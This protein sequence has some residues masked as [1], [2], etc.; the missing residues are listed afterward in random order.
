M[1]SRAALQHSRRMRDLVCPPRPD[2]FAAYKCGVRVRVIIGEYA[3]SVG[4]VF[5]CNDRGRVH[6][7]VPPFAHVYI[8][9]DLLQVLDGGENTKGILRG[10]TPVPVINW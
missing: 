1:S 8:P 4:I 2:P 3:G 5:S 9:H 7:H 10:I 6:V